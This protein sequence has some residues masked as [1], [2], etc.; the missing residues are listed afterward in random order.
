MCQQQVFFVR[1]NG[2]SVWFDE[3]GWP[4]PKHACFDDPPSRVPGSAVDLATRLRE[5]ATEHHD[6]LLG[7][8]IEG[9]KQAPL[10]LRM[11]RMHC[12]DGRVRTVFLPPQWLAETLVGRFVAVSLD[13]LKVRF[14]DSGLVLQFIP[15]GA[16]L[17]LAGRQTLLQAATGPAV[18]IFSSEDSANP[19]FVKRRSL[20]ASLRV[21]MTPCGEPA[22]PSSVQLVA[23]ASDVKANAL[24][25]AEVSWRSLNPEVATVD[26][27][28]L[29]TALSGGEA[30]IVASFGRTHSSVMVR[31]L[32]SRPVFAFR[33]EDR[34]V[35][36]NQHWVRN[37]P[38]GPQLAIQEV[39]V[40]GTVIE[41]PRCADGLVWWN[42]HWDV[43]PDGWSLQGALGL[44][45]Q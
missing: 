16:D 23:Q 45:A 30:E 7:V 43:K 6:I 34:V 15:S 24:T 26:A 32:E 39:G 20:I 8:L 40:Q 36:I 18:T 27:T 21:G 1:H 29:V 10:A 44:V 9:C 12:S 19:A 14:L 33:P 17:P 4:W 5:A 3:L 28:G 35:A 41:G 13:A 42:I 22:T 31:V 11:F 2:G 37:T 38:D 25:G